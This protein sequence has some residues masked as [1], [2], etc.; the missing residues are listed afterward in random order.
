MQEE[1]E[2]KKRKKKKRKEE[3]KKTAQYHNPARRSRALVTAVR[4]T[5]SEWEQRAKG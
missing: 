1:E 2:Q 4:G 5:G 3:R